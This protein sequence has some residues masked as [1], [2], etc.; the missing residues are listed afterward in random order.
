MNMTHITN[1]PGCKKGA[2]SQTIQELADLLQRLLHQMQRIF[3]SLQH[4]TS[5]IED[6][7]R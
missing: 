3:C 7:R 2:N 6:E 1:C 5:H 4:G